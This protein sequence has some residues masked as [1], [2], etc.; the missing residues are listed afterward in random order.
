MMAFLDRFRRNVV[1]RWRIMVALVLVG[2][3]MSALTGGGLG[4]GDYLNPGWLVINF[5]LLGITYLAI[6]L[7]IS[8]LKRG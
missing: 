8:A 1:A 3:L 2:P 5:V 7:V 6:V 4:L